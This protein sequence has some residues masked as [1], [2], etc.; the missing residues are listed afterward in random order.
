MRP[1]VGARSAEGQGSPGGTKL[2]VVCSRAGPACHEWAAQQG[3]EPEVKE[4]LPRPA[5]PLPLP[6]P[7]PPPA[8]TPP[9]P[10]PGPAAPAAQARPAAP[11]RAR[12][13]PHF[14][15]TP[16][17]AVR[18]R[19][20]EPALPS[21]PPPRSQRAGPAGVGRPGAAAWAAARPRLGAGQT[22]R[23]ARGPSARPSLQRQAAGGSVRAGGLLSTH[24]TGVSLDHRAG[25]H[26][27]LLSEG[28]RGRA[29]CPKPSQPWRAA[30]CPPG[31]RLDASGP[32]CCWA[33][34]QETRREA[35]P[36]VVRY[37]WRWLQAGGGRQGGRAGRSLSGGAA[38]VARPCL[39]MTCSASHTWRAARHGA[40][41]RG[42]P[43]DVVER[44]LGHLHGRHDLLGLQSACAWNSP[45]PYRTPCANCTARKQCPCPYA[46][47]HA[48]QNA[49]PPTVVIL[50]IPAHA[51]PQLRLPLPW[52]C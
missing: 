16:P 43:L 25:L 14:R 37:F 39:K 22:G 28:G 30:L 20:G 33:V 26:C 51:L 45:L 34:S 44:E 18:H 4:P 52:P 31:S 11:R 42:A 5:P 48:T 1:A 19:R 6:R 49:V 35:V 10:H 27:S 47:C 38:N 24:R 41:R 2:R 12:A 15:P 40:A 9:C 23:R 8:P 7:A 50:C 17:G 29:P 13:A 3:T 36:S 46:P 21:P 32:S